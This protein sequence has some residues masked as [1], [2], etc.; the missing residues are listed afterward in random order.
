MTF[1][2]IATTCVAFVFAAV[3]AAQDTTWVQT[4]TWE[5]Q[6]NPE[7]AYDSPG[8]RWFN[9][10]DGSQDYQKILM[11]YNL[12]CFEDGTA[13]GLGFPCGE[14]DYLSYSYLFEHTGML[15]SNYVNHPHFL[16]NNQNF[17]ELPLR[18]EG[19]SDFFQEEWT[20]TTV[21]E[22]TSETVV[23]LAM[24]AENTTYPMGGFLP[25]M[26]T[27][28]LWTAEE[29]TAAGMTAGDIDG[30]RLYV[31]YAIEDYQ[32]VRIRVA[33]VAST[34]ITAMQDADWT[35][36]YTY[37]NDPGMWW[38]HYHFNSPIPWDGTS[39]LLV[40]WSYEN[41]GFGLDNT[42]GAG[43]AGYNN[44]VVAGN[45]QDRY[46]RFNWWDAIQVPA[47]AFAEVSDQVTI[48][49]WLRGG[50]ELPVNSTTFEGVNANNQRVLNTHLPWGNS[51]MYW[52]AGQDGGYDRI[53]A[54]AAED[55]IKGEWNHWTFTKNTNTGVMNIYLNGALWLTGADKDNPMDG[56]VKFFIGGNAGQG[57]FWYGDMDEF[58]V[59]DVELDAATISDWLYKDITPDHPAWSNL[60]VYY[61][62]NAEGGGL[63]DDASPN[64]FH[65]LMVGSPERKDYDA[66]ELFR[67]I[68]VESVRPDI[69]FVSGEYVTS[70]TTQIVTDEVPV[71]P[72]ILAEYEVDEYDVA[73]ASIGDRW[74]EGYGVT[75]D[76]NG[77]AIDS[78]FYPADDNQ[79]NDS[80]FWYQAPFEVVNRIEIGRYITPYG[81]GLDLD[82]DGWTWV[83]DVTDY[84]PLLRD[85]VELQCGN[86]QE[87]LDM[88]F[89][90]IH[91]EP[92][93]DIHHLENVWSGSFACNN[94]EDNI[95]EQTLSVADDVEGV[96]FKARTSGHGNPGCAEFCFNTHGVNLNGATNWEW[97]IMQEC[98]DNGLYPQ[99]GTWVY[100]RGGWCPGAD[101]PTRDVEL[102]PFLNGDNTFTLDYEANTLTQGN[103]VFEGQ[104]VTYGAPNFQH[105]V[106]VSEI[107]SPSNN[108][109]Y[110]RFNPTCTDVRF[111]IRNNGEQP[112]TSVVITYGVEGD[113]M[114]TTTWTGNLGF[115]DSEQIQLTY[116]HPSLYAGGEESFANFVVTLSMPNGVADEQDNNNTAVSTFNRPEVFT[117]VE[118]EDDE[119]DNRLIFW[120]GTNN[121]YW[122]TEYE[123]YDRVGNTVFFND[124]FTGSESYRDT[125]AINEGCYTLTLFDSGDDGLSFFANDETN[126]SFRLKQVQ[127]PTLHT[128]EP[129]FGKYISKTFYWDTDLVSVEEVPEQT[130]NVIVYPNPTSGGVQVKYSGMRGSVDLTIHDAQGRI[131]RSERLP[132]TNGSGTADLADWEGESGMYLIQLTDGTQRVLRR[133]IRE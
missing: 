26:R 97:E 93:R 71:P 59:F 23:E 107:L 4:Y 65:G 53:N 47:G 98:A 129:D 7:T 6:N 78:V 57:T 87:L 76:P 9:F 125:L 25:Q 72:T 96:R 12:K 128:F 30:L 37:D 73:L 115:L 132:N 32:E 95:P 11:Y 42:V 108:K 5:A 33:Q 118:D 68:Q 46:L 122:E 36:A 60:Q 27:Q 41:V 61:P 82:D 119:D 3:L 103:Y 126:G 16:F 49:M 63:V 17:E 88:K 110:N 21:D 58:A 51:N 24:D 19:Y 55:A 121:H 67:N 48:S 14:W 105:E 70:T 22:T 52:D 89:A 120:L 38:T 84:M 77:L 20:L 83:F 111:V 13:G 1:P 116:D 8:R 44:T 127:G 130:A 112:L 43:D 75:Y 15:D 79:M 66:Q 2:R 133:V 40:E 113:V 92:A 85:S 117:Y 80:L 74:E 29:L 91:G 18:D 100:D 31:T 114:E 50:D 106:E 124:D 81:I 10:P 28:M 102:T 109:L 35:E 54:A 62:F 45:A 86:W 99:G 64:S 56:I 39:S 101:V 90:F 69:Q 131:L 123:L 94:W 104:L 34:E